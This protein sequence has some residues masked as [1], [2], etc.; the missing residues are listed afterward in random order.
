MANSQ[1]GA[2]TSNDFVDKRRGRNYNNI[3]LTEAANYPS[4]SLMRTRLAAISG[5]T[6]TAARLD[7]MTVNDMVYALRMHT[8]DSAGV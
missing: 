3:S 6:F 1:V 4:V 2:H 8:A 5:T 7:A